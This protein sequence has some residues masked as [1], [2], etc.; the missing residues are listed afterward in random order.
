MNNLEATAKLFIAV[1]V[2]IAVTGILLWIGSKLGL[3][4]FR[5]PGDIVIKKGNFTLYFPWVTCIVV[6]VILSFILYLF[7]R[8]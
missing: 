8:R 2:I 3:S 1:G 5:L 7:G 6:S 4:G